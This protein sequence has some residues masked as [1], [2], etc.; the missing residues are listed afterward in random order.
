[1]NEFAYMTLTTGLTTTGNALWLS[2]DE[3]DG[4]S[5][6]VTTTG[7]LTGTFRFY[8]SND[9]RARPDN[10]AAVKAAA[11]W[12]EFTS[13]VSAMIVNP[14]AG[15]TTF[16]VMVDNFKRAYLRMDYVHTSGTGTV[17][18]LFSGRRG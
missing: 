15:A 14:A 8:W 6:Q 10:S 9:P 16:E 12:R 7:T 18:A 17:S 1:M 13:D 5:M 3:I 11:D 2:P 4:W